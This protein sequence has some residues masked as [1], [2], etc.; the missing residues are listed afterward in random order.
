MKRISVYIFVIIL[1]PVLCSCM[2]RGPYPPQLHQSPDQVV[3]VEFVDG[4]NETELFKIREDGY[5]VKNIFCHADLQ[6][7]DTVYKTVVDKTIQVWSGHIHFI[8]D[9]NNFHNIGA[10]FSFTFNDVN[11]NEITNPVEYL[12]RQSSYDSPIIIGITIQED[13]EAHLEDN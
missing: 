11:G 1:V 4:R 7:W 5:E 2:R 6:H 3:K 8:W 12:N 10:M 13:I 9:V